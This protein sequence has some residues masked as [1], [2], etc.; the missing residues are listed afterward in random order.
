MNEDGERLFHFNMVWGDRMKSDFLR[1]WQVCETALLPETEVREHVQ[2]CSEITCIVSGTGEITTN[3]TVF[4]VKAGDIHVIAKG[5][6]HRVTASS[7]EK[8]HYICVGFNFEG[9][10]EEYAEVCAFYGSSPAALAACTNDVRMLLDMLIGEFYAPEEE[11]QRAVADL[12][13]LILIKVR[14]CFFHISG[15]AVR[16]GQTA[17]RHNTVYKVI[18]YIDSNIY[19]VRSVGEIAEKLFYTES[20]LS[21]VFRRKMGITLQTYIREKKL[22]TAKI[23]LEYGSLSISEVAELLH[24][25]SVQSLTRGFKKLYGIT[26]YQYISEKRKENSHDS[27]KNGI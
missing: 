22:E 12:L 10:P 8:L 17:G 16:G 11:Q 24:F 26:P 23:L 6:R 21:T 25:D 20:Y 3:D 13:R 7:G 2:I 18:K 19:T 15:K 4:P 14:R 1:V 5:D 27:R 9:I